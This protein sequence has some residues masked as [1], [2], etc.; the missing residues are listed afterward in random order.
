[1]ASGLTAVRFSRTPARDVITLSRSVPLVVLG[2]SDRIIL[3]TISGGA[4]RTISWILRR[5]N[6]PYL[7][8]C[9]PLIGEV[10]R[11]SKVT[12]VRYERDRPGELIHMDV[13]KLERILPGGGWKAW[14]HQMGPTALKRDTRV[15]YN[16]VH[17]PVDDY[18]RLATQR[19]ST[20]RKVTPH[21]GS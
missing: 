16:Y 13:K 19:S 14:G 18:S 12:T 6:V 20:M 11:A 5:H 4:A 17:S 15:G 1:M 8:E 3:L 21:P 10:I 7:D 2:R 9:D